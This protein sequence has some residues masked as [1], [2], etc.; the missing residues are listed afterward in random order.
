[1]KNKQ[2]YIV[3]QYRTKSNVPRAESFREDILTA[4]EVENKPKLWQVKRKAL[5]YFTYN[6]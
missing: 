4:H 6:S 2:R 3:Y 5:N 1:M